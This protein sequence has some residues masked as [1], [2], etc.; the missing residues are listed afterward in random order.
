MARERAISCRPGH[1]SGKPIKS[2]TAFSILQSLAAPL[3]DE[4]QGLAKTIQD[5]ISQETLNQLRTQVEEQAHRIEALEAQV[6]HYQAEAETGLA[7]AA[8]VEERNIVLNRQNWQ[9]RQDLLELDAWKHKVRI[10]IQE[11][12]QIEAKLDLFVSDFEAMEMTLDQV[13]LFAL[14]LPEEY[15]LPLLTILRQFPGQS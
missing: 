3:R 7:L 14:G 12:Q 10:L 5:E 1:G 15:K 4:L 8:E 9:L 6:V 11:R 13:N 2:G